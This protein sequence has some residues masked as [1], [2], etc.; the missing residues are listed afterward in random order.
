MNAHTPTP[1]VVS[2]TCGARILFN[3]SAGIDCVDATAPGPEEARYRDVAH[4]VRCVNAH[5]EL[6]AALRELVAE[7]DNDFHHD[8]EGFNMARDA[9]AKLD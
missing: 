5:D 9:L 3:G 1:W 6:V 8:T 7:R 4:I 2:Q